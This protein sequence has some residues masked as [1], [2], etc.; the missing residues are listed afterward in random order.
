MVKKMFIS[1]IFVT[2]MILPTQSVVANEISV[3]ALETNNNEIDTGYFSV[4]SLLVGELNILY[5]DGFSSL[6]VEVMPALPK[7]RQYD[8]GWSGGYVPW[9]NSILYINATSGVDYVRYTV[10]ANG[11]YARLSNFSN[12]SYSIALYTLSNLYA[13]VWI[14]NATNTTNALAEWSAVATLMQGGVVVGTKNM[15]VRMELRYD[16]KTRLTYKFF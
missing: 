16:G 4:E 1:I 5:D 11:Q 14:S 9:E 2:C 13:G 6:S 7:L 15:Y 3:D 10:T 8:S 12:L